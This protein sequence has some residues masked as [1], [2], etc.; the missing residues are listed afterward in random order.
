M[1][2]LLG[3]VK[4]LTRGYVK[5]TSMLTKATVVEIIPSTTVALVQTVVSLT[6]PI[7]TFTL[8]YFDSRNLKRKG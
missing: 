4:V 6:Y 7:N 1:S 2:L 3:S 5:A 8:S